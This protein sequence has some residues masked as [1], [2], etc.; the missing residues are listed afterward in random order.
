ML[1]FYFVY[2]SKEIISRCYQAF[3]N[4][5]TFLYV[6]YSLLYTVWYGMVQ[7]AAKA[8]ERLWCSN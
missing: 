1:E 4:T 5:A 2:K 3:R 8:N 7:S 6:S